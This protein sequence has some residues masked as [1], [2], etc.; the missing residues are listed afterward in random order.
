MLRGDCD[1]LDAGFFVGF[2]VWFE[3]LAGVVAHPLLQRGSRPIE[4]ASG[5]LPRGGQ[6]TSYDPGGGWAVSEL[7]ATMRRT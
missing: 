7:R 6:G 4:S 5:L 1:G 3:R 2:W